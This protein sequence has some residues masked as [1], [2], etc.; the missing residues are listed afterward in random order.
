MILTCPQCAARYQV[1]GSK[2]P[3]SGRTVR[4][5]KC[6]HSWQQMPE[7]A[8]PAPEPELAVVESVPEPVPAPAPAPEPAP[9]VAAFA[10]AAEVER[11]ARRVSIPAEPKPSGPGWGSRIAV[12]GGWIGLIV[13]VLVIGWSAVAYRQDVANVWPRSASLYSALGLKV[14]ATGIAFSGVTYKTETE[15]NT[16]VLA[17]SGQL[18]NISPRELPVPQIRVS[19]TDGERHE[20]YH[21]TFVPSVTAMKPGQVVPFLTRLASPPPARHLELR[22]ARAGE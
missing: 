8:P 5:A 19:L 9:Q 16:P 2:F 12:I 22:F 1:D 14:N 11:P 10:P 6:G 7:G 21:W 17:V 13:V 4:C 15:D 20:I 18:V 3:P